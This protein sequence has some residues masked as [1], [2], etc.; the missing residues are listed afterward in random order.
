[1]FKDLSVLDNEDKLRFLLKIK[2]NDLLLI[3]A[4]LNLT[5][6]NSFRARVEPFI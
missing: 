5:R 4:Y 3:R 6:I 2:H 1:M